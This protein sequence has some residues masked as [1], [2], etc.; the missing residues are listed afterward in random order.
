MPIRGRCWIR[1]ARSARVAGLALNPPTPL[2]AIEASLPHCD[3][4]LVMS[5][6]PGF[7][8]QEFDPVALDKAADAQARGPTSMPCSKSTAAS[9]IDTVGACA[10][11]GTDCLSPARRFF[12][13]DDYRGPRSANC[14]RSEAANMELEIASTTGFEDC[15][16]FVCSDLLIR[17]GATEY[18]QQ[19][20]VQGTLDIPLC[21]DG[22]QQVET[23]I[24][25]L[26]EQPIAAIY[27][28][29]AVGRA[30]GRALGE[31]FDVK[32]KTLDNCRI[33]T[34]ACGRGCWCPT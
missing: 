4:V 10:E 13:R 23:M 18:D 24:E 30:N 22:R 28:S 15:A 8:G 9:T 2:S 20:R 32:V 26:R 27:T 1:F 6:M 11:A 31:A 19:G 29:P 21:E 17:P 14:V 3:L 33:S 12:T 25:E 34:T 7:G 5:V 16:C